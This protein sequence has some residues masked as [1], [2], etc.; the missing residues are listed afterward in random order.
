MVCLNRQSQRLVFAIVAG[1]AVIC[2]IVLTLIPPTLSAVALVVAIITLM[3]SVF[4]FSIK[5]YFFML[6]PMLRMKHMSM[7]IDS[8]EPFYMAA[9]G[10]AI[11]VRRDNDIFAT[12]FIKIPIYSSATEMSDEEKYNFSLLFARLISISKSPIRISSQLHSIN[13]DDYISRIGAKLNECEVRYNTIQGDA[14]ADPKALERVK[15]EVTMWRNLL[16]N[17][18]R[19]NSQQLEVYAT[20]TALGNSEEEASNLVAIKADEIAAGIS[21]TLGISATVITGNEILVFIEPDYMIPPA[22]I[23]EVMKFRG[24]NPA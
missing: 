24:T 23:G 11:M 21:A 15:G 6:G 20:V 22:T 12:A 13:K 4:A 5:D 3:L 1:A 8:N 10:N 19:S 7:V 2:L 17:V 18:S 14:N 9:N 16:D